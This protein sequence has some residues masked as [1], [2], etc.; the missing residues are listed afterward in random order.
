MSDCTSTLLNDIT[1]EC[2]NAPIGGIEQNV[3]IVKK[4]DVLNVTY[5]G[6]RPLVVTSIQLTPGAAVCKLEGIKQANGKAWELVKK[7]NAPD[8]YKHTFSGVIFNPSALNKQNAAVL[9]DGAKYVIIIEQM[10]KGAGSADAFEILGLHS[11]LEMSSMTN[12]SKEND[13]MIVFE[14]ASVDGFEEPTPPKNFMKYTSNTPDYT[15]TKT[16]FDAQLV[17]ATPST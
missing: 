13:N 5:D 16:L 1:F 7:E 6:T 3:L 11:G 15:A 12:S 9:A 14:M 2:A 17:A 10:W 4:K 8:K